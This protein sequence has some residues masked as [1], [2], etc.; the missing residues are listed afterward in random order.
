MKA[1]VEF[2][3]IG[4]K[5]D[6]IEGAGRDLPYVEFADSEKV[7][8]GEPAEV[9]IPLSQASWKTQATEWRFEATVPAG[10]VHRLLIIQAGTKRARRG[11]AQPIAARTEGL[12]HGADEPDLA[13]GARQAKGARR[14]AARHG[15]GR[16]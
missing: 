15:C 3:Q 1:V 6:K 11:Q 14:P 4:G 8:Q 16:R 7:R 13:S 12:R 9:L 5:S 2:M 10:Q